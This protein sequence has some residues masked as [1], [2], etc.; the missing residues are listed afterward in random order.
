VKGRQKG[1]LPRPKGR[2]VRLYNFLGKRDLR[3]SEIMQHCAAAGGYS[4]DLHQSL[5]IEG[6][7]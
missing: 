7:A 3:R 6:P 5:R 2:G 4:V 1:A